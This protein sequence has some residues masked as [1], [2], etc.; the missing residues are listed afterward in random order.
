MLVFSSLF[1]VSKNFTTEEFV[2]LASKWI[3]NDK[4]RYDFDEFIWDKSPIFSVFDRS[5][6]VEFSIQ[7]CVEIQSTAI[8]LK[9]TELNIEWITDLILSDNMLAIQLQRNSSDNVSYIPNFHTPYILKMIFENNY[10]GEDNGLPITGKPLLVSHNDIDKIT[11]LLDN[12]CNYKLPIVYVSQK[13]DGKYVV[14]TLRLSKELAGIAHIWVENDA[15]ISKKIKTRNISAKPYAGAVQIFYSN[16][17]TKRF[18]PNPTELEREIIKNIKSAII[19]RIL[20]IKIDEKYQYYYVSQNI[21]QY[22]IQNIK[23]EKEKN[24]KQY[25]DDVNKLIE[26]CDTLEQERNILLDEN[27]RL[28]AELNDCKSINMMQ[29]DQIDTY[30]EKINEMLNADNAPLLYYG[31]EKDLYDNEQADII[32]DILTD[33]L[34]KNIERAH[35]EPRRKH[36]L[37]SILKRNKSSGNL[38]E[39]INTVERVFKKPKLSSQDKNDLKKAGVYIISEKSHYRLLLENNSRYYTTVAKTTSDKGHANK[40]VTSNIKRKFF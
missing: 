14:D 29:Q 32:I 30:S 39:R 1:P 11:A 19:S 31:E 21:F 16:G 4:S 23:V 8:R 15:S 25:T 20:Q 2:E 10:G 33:V 13:S 40:N 17:Y 26:M 6:D 7:N 3:L 36:I 9:K 28:Q 27:K 12:T 38:K 18:V 22:K 24:D 34:D 35:P 5:G 37:E